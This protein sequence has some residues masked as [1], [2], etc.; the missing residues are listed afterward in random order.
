MMIKTIADVDPSQMHLTDT[1]YNILKNS[2]KT[3]DKDK[4]FILTDME[5]E[6]KLIIHNVITPQTRR[7]KT[8]DNPL[9]RIPTGRY[10]ITPE[11]ERYL[12]YKNKEVRKEHSENIKWWITTGIAVLALILAILSLSLDHT[13]QKRIADIETQE[14]T[15]EIVDAS[16]MIN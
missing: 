15:I 8:S 10:L 14:S 2:Y 4:T 7:D 1:E 5:Y 11:G 3:T 16:N 9:N 12:E 6:Q 13:N